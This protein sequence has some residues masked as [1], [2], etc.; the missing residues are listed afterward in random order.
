MKTICALNPT[1]VNMRYKWIWQPQMHFSINSSLSRVSSLRWNNNLNQL[2]C[3]V[4]LSFRYF[5]INANGYKIGSPMGCELK[6]GK[7]LSISYLPNRKAKTW[8][9][10]ERRSRI[11]VSCDKIQSCL[12][13]SLDMQLT[14]H[15]F[16]TS[17]CCSRFWVG[18]TFCWD[19]QV[20][21]QWHAPC[22]WS[23]CEVFV[24]PCVENYHNYEGSNRNDDAPMW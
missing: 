14:Q 7:T 9:P 15:S 5:V 1:S 18:Q 24:Y 6:N 23:L 16:G 4:S 3:G 21:R 13:H 19:C 8:S 22:C 12:I 17:V 11:A 2:N 20:F 10:L